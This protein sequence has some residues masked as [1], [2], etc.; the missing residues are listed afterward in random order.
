MLLNG[1][2]Q[3][4]QVVRDL[5]AA[6]ANWVKLYGAGPFYVADFKMEQGQFYRGQPTILDVSV[7]IGYSGS[8]NVELLRPNRP[9]PSIYHELLD[10]YGEGIH[11]FWRRGENV[12]ADVA[13]FEAMGCP[14][15][16]SGEVPGVTRSYFVDTRPAIGVYTELQE[17][18]GA[19]RAA[20]DE[21]HQ[22]HLS[23]DGKTDPVRPYPTLKF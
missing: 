9:G 10:T 23:W 13:R 11:H 8:L 18:S 16:A 21:M 1:I 17:V 22:A 14:L 3:V 15:V 20:L 6:I 5:D 4:C 2:T 19:V 12:D 7:A